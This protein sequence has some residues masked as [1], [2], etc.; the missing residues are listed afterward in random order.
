MRLLK[1]M[2]RYD[3]DVEQVR[4]GLQ[5]VEERHHGEGRNCGRFRHHGEGRHWGKF[6]HH[7]EGQHCGRSRHEQRE[8]LKAKYATQLAELTTAGIDVNSPCTLRL[9]EK[10]QGDITKVGFL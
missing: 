6:G 9:L 2:E 5:N 4:K 8:E 3:G 10:N 7:G 1:M